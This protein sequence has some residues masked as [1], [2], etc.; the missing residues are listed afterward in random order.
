MTS[1][2]RCQPDLESDENKPLKRKAKDFESETAQSAKSIRKRVSFG[3]SKVINYT[4]NTEEIKDYEV[5]IELQKCEE[6]L[7]HHQNEE[8]NFLNQVEKSKT[9]LGNLLGQLKTQMG[10]PTT[11][12]ENELQTLYSLLAEEQQLA[13]DMEKENQEYYTRVAQAINKLEDNL[14]NIS[15][16]NESEKKHDIL[17]RIQTKQKHQQYK[18][19]M[20]LFKSAGIKIQRNTDSYDIS[21]KKSSYSITPMASYFIIMV[22]HDPLNLFQ[23]GVHKIPALQFKYLTHRLLLE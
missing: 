20:N 19:I 1:P 7:F 11:P 2:A 6:Q 10:I 8:K 14:R 18:F 9:R 3:A 22:S 21:Y 23:P 5:D 12:T 17:S 15:S 13:E 16:A 4:T